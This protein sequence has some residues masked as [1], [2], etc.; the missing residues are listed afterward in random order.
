MVHSKKENRIEE[1]PHGVKVST[2]LAAV[3]EDKF[4]LGKI[5]TDKV[6]SPRARSRSIIQAK[7]LALEM[8]ALPKN[9]NVELLLT[10]TPKGERN[11]NLTENQE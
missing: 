4:V 1:V 2:W 6:T 10:D 8:K 11:W 9:A 7:L 5:D 3:Q